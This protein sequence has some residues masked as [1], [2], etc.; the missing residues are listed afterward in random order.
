M[1]SN[2]VEITAD[3]VGAAMA[4]AVPATDTAWSHK[5]TTLHFRARDEPSSGLG[6]LLGG[7]RGRGIAVHLDPSPVPA[8]PFIWSTQVRFPR[9]AGV[10]ES[11]ARAGVAW[12]MWWAVGQ[13]DLTTL[14]ERARML[15]FTGFAGPALA[16]PWFVRLHAAATGA[17]PADP[18]RVSAS[19]TSPL[20]PRLTDDGI[21]D[22]I[23]LASDEL[24]SDQLKALAYEQWQARATE[25]GYDLS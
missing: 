18:V 13:G 2:E 3:D 10:A 17:D 21:E 19:V 8:G 11:L 9:G 6:R 24:H 4:L 23:R 15:V 25:V 12:P 16:L 20:N 22:V 14:V 5:Q 1:N 7:G